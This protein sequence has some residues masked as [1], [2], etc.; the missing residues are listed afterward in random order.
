MQKPHFLK[1]AGFFI[2][3]TGLKPREKILPQFHLGQLDETTNLSQ[4]SSDTSQN[5]SF[6]ITDTSGVARECL[7]LHIQSAVVSF[8]EHFQRATVAYASS[9][10][11]DS[12]ANF[13][14]RVL[15]TDEQ[16]VAA[17]T[18]SASNGRTHTAKDEQFFS[19]CSGV[20][21]GSTSGTISVCGT[22][23]VGTITNGCERLGNSCIL[24][25]QLSIQ[26]VG[27]LD[28]CDGFFE[29]CGFSL[30]SLERSLSGS[31]SVNQT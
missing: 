17:G 5:D 11:V 16:L 3:S 26:A 31:Q 15:G 6:E 8:P 27:L 4:V 9:D 7:L 2:C 20:S 28:I 25:F 23:H 10:R 21:N 29:R 19:G 13:H 1:E 12:S 14:Q 30:L 24:G 22:K 18:E